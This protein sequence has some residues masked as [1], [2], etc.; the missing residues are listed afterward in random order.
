ME[1]RWDIEVRIT[2]GQVLVLIFTQPIHRKAGSVLRPCVCVCVCV[3][4]WLFSLNF[5]DIQFVGVH[6]YKQG[7]ELMG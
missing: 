6:G 5:S 3:C 4:L 1:V 2:W 7:Q